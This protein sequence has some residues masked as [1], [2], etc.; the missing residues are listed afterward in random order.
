MNKQGILYGVGVGPGDPELL[1]LKAVKTIKTAD[2]I[3][4]PITEKNKKSIALEIAE[5][6]IPK[7]SKIVHL[8]FPMVSDEKTKSNAWEEAKKVIIEFLEKNKNVIFLTLG[9]PM[10]YSTFIYVMEIIKNYKFQIVTIPGITS[11]S[12]IAA[13][14]N[15]PLAL[16][17]EILEIIPLA[18]NVKVLYKELASEKNIVIMKIY[19]NFN[20]VIGVLKK[21]KRLGKAIMVSNAG[22]KNKKIFLDLNDLK[23]DKAE[24]L[25]TIISKK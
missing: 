25:S 19:K 12:A 1:T 13:E 21:H 14:T 2:V 8:I 17:D 18:N 6:Y 11:F 16:D 4:V 7:K 20:K 22:L 9:D 15:T 24:Y 3:I 10:L 5:K 23:I